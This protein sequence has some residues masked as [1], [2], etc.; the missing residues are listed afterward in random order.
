MWAAF[1]IPLAL[2]FLILGVYSSFIVRIPEGTSAL[3]SKGR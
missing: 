2:I 3:L 1:G